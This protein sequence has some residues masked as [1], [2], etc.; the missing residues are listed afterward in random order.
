MKAKN[1]ALYFMGIH[2]SIGIL[3]PKKNGKGYLKSPLGGH[4]TNK[5]YHEFQQLN[6]NY[7]GDCVDIDGYLNVGFGLNSWDKGYED[8][9]KEV[10]EGIVEVFTQCKG[11]K[12]IDHPTFWSHIK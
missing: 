7:A 12:E 4:H 9:I 3:I 8:A 1:N 5:K 10:L 6:L 11:Y 2:D